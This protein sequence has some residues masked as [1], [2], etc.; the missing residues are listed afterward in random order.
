[1]TTSEHLSSPDVAELAKAMVKVQQ[2]LM[3]ACKDAEN[4]FVKTR[5]ASLNSVIE[6]CRDALIA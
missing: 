6:A 4:P 5:Y 1:M 3:P 2:A